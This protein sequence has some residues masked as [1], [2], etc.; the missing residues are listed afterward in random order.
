MALIGEQ[1]AYAGDPLGLFNASISWNDDVGAPP[2]EQS[3]QVDGGQ[4]LVD[5]NWY[6]TAADQYRQ[7]IPA[8]KTALDAIRTHYSDS[9]SAA[10]ASTSIGIT[11]FWVSIGAGLLGL[12]IK[13]AP[14]IVAFC[15]GAGAPLGAA[16]LIEA[17]A[18]LA[19]AVGVAIGA[20]V[21][22]LALAQSKLSTASSS[23]LT[24]WPTFAL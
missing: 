5:D 22:A 21:G 4:L 10:L 15:T 11:A 16:I 1:L 8:Q 12:V 24:T 2:S 14:A 19:I 7:K 17:G 20:L 18:A 3:W 13:F 23:G 6:G 9:I